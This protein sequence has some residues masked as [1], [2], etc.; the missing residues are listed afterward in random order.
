MERFT[1]RPDGH[2]GDV[3]QWRPVISFTDLS[4]IPRPI[5]WTMAFDGKGKLLKATHAATPK[6]REKI[7]QNTPVEVQG[8]LVQQRN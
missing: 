7:V 8:K 5:Q 1:I 2:P 4:A 6:L 3:S